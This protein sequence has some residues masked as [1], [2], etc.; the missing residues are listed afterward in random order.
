MIRGKRSRAGI[1]P[2]LV[3]FGG[4]LQA[5]GARTS[6]LRLPTADSTR[7]AQVAPGVIYDFSWYAAGPWAVH[8]LT[9][10]PRACGIAFRTIK[11]DGGVVGRST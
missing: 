1:F 7:T 5:C 10:A 2:A 4:L 6:E 11:A 8:T 3:C 9:I